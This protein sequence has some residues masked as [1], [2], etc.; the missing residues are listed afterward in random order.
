MAISSFVVDENC[1]DGLPSELK[2]C[3]ILCGSWGVVHFQDDQ[4]GGEYEHR[5]LKCDATWTGCSI[6]SSL[7]PTE[8]LSDATKI[9]K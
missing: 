3:C 9:E 5:C 7:T 2:D 8:R 1:H 6:S 4:A